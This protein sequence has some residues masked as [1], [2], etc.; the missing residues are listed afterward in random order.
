[1]SVVPLGLSLPGAVLRRWDRKALVLG[2]AFGYVAGYSLVD[3]FSNVKPLLSLGI[4]PWN[5][6]AGLAL[7]FLLFLGPRWLPVTILAA[8]VSDALLRGASITSPAALCASVWVASSYAVLAGVL[9]RWQLAAP[10]STAIGAVRFAGASILGTFVVAAGYVAIFVA[11]GYLSPEYAVRGTTRYWVGDLT[12]VLTLTPLLMYLQRWRA[13]LAVIKRH[14]FELLLQLSVIVLALWFVFSL[15]ADDQLRFFYLLFVP[16]IW[17]AM[18]W[19]LPGGALAV[20]AIQMGLAIVAQ[21]EIPIYRFIYL[22]SLMLTLSLTALFLGAV[23]TERWQVL[24]RVAA[25]EAEQRAL[26]TMAPDGVM[27]VGA[28]GTIRMANPAATRLFGNKLESQRDSHLSDVLPGLHLGCADGRATLEGC[29]ADGGTFPAE[30][31]WARLD[32]PANEGF[33]VTVRDA[34]ERLRAEEQ[35]RG[36]DAALARAMRF[37]VAGELASALTHELNQPITALVSYLQA[38]EILADRTEA[39][40]DRLKSTLGKAAQQAIRAS[41]V[42]RRL[43]DFYRSGALKR[44]RLEIRLICDAAA[45]AFQDRLR[46]TEVSLTV[47]VASSVPPV[48]GD[49]TQLEI[50]LHNLIGNAIDSLAQNPMSRRSIELSAEWNERELTLRVEDSGP[51]VPAELS[52][53]L[54]EPFM[55]N[56]PDGMGLGLAISRSLIRARGG[57]LFYGA[58]RKLGGAAFTIRLPFAISPDAPLI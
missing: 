12:G 46:R 37:A 4:T 20:L 52:S 2:V 39:G 55:T 35:L 49:S 33:L 57:E 5:P 58:S 40:D 43:R 30:I 42:L 13:S 41:E 14:V 36:R 31:A 19:G 34:T 23:V 3:W 16:V 38:S 24:Q 17:I 18:R 15:P 10:I 25:R 48:E 22:Q 45:H 56:K 47:V 21:S 29:R 53:K 11:F 44:E 8:A 7:A 51:G 9:R 6:Q 50:V 28:S 27:S 1:M 54:F 32:A 26:L